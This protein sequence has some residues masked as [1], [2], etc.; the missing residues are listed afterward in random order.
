[1][2]TS[3]S[4]V[5]AEF[6]CGG[7]SKVEWV[8]CQKSAMGHLICDQRG[9]EGGLWRGPESKDSILEQP[10]IA[11]FGRYQPVLIQSFKFQS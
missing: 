3:N 10:L 8:V 1:M 7:G 6:Q 2:R 5:T 11:F 9:V 4:V